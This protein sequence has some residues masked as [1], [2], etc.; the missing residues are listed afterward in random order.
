MKVKGI[1]HVSI[2]AKDMKASTDFYGEVLGFRQ[3]ETVPFDGFSI[4]YFEVPGGGRLELFDYGGKNPR[5][6][7]EENEVGLRH[8]AFSVE[9]VDEEEKAPEERGGDD[10]A[11]DNGPPVAG[12]RVLLF[13]DPNGVTL[14]FCERLVAPRGAPS[15]T[16]TVLCIG[17][18]V[19][20]RDLEIIEEVREMK[21]TLLLVLVVAIAMVFA[22]TGCSKA[23]EKAAAPSVSAGGATAEDVM[24]N[25]QEVQE[26]PARS[27]SDLSWEGPLNDY[28]KAIMCNVQYTLEQKY[29]DRVAKVIYAPAD[30]DKNKQIN[31]VEDLLT[32]KIDLLL[33]QPISESAG[34]AIIEKAMGMGIPVI[35]FGAGLLTD[36]YVSYCNI[37]N[38]GIGVA[39]TD[40][41]SSRW[42]RRAR[43]SR[44]SASRAAATPRITS[45]GARRRSRSTRTS[46]W[47][48][49]STPTT[50]RPRQSSPWKRS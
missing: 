37:D 26:E 8:L 16:L 22:L 38:Y 5:T 21:K 32:K 31:T 23:K 6:A 11:A 34:V 29:K 7:R 9:D 19:P 1:D 12:R 20:V 24:V 48:T 27:P 41:V 42:A 46:R 25:T 43:S 47:R 4:V 10:H 40:W 36:N 3:M 28:S 17:Y 39:E 45:G 18:P 35:V 50:P 49:G 33:Y 15:G 13:L 14:E 44:W 2:N 30:G